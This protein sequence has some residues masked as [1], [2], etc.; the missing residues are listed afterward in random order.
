MVIWLHF[1]FLAAYSYF[2]L[3]STPQSC[4]YHSQSLL[5]AF[6][7]EKVVSGPTSM[8]KAAMA[9]DIFGHE[10]ES[11]AS[12][13]IQKHTISF[14]V[15]LQLLRGMPSQDEAFYRDCSANG[16]FLTI[17]KWRLLKG[18]DCVWLGGWVGSTLKVSRPAATLCMLVDPGASRELPFVTGGD[19]LMPSGLQHVSMCQWALDLSLRRPHASLNN[20]NWVSQESLIAVIELSDC[21]IFT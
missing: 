17:L 10:Q 5:P 12:S 7:E 6:L 20:C 1:R 21:V 9:P 19:R 16:A 11:L 18:W 15:F 8:H 13:R 14:S 2:Q 4:D 3:S